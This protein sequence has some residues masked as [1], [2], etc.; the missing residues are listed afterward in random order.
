MN[1]YKVEAKSRN[2]LRILAKEIRALLG[3]SNQIYFP[4]VELLDVFS[5]MF[6]NFSYE[7]VSDNKLPSEEHAQIH[8]FEGK[9]HVVI[10]ESVYERACN[11]EGRDRMTVVHEESHFI[12]ICVYGF[13]LKEHS[14]NA[15][16]AYNDPEWQAKCLAAELM[17]PYDLTKHMSPEEIVDKCGVSQEAADYQY[18]KMH[19]GGEDYY[20]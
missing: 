12:T 20:D 19:E 6:D 15:I 9:G 18:R 7:I 4:A 2:D 11:G 5:E 8:V 10:K 17:I 16:K 3:L 13:K 14:S 1:S